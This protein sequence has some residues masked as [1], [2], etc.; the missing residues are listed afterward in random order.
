MEPQ[1]S[2]IFFSLK[3]FD[4]E[5]KIGLNNAVSGGKGFYGA[6]CPP[7]ILDHVGL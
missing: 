4:V 7:C 3:P 5:L 6:N 1:R 2:T